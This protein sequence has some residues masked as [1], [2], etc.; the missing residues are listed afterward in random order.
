MTTE[1]LQKKANLPPDHIHNCVEPLV[2]LITPV[3]ELLK[4]F[5]RT[6]YYGSKR[7]LIRWLYS[8]FS[9]YN[10]STVLDLFGGTASVSQLFRVMN[11]K[12]TYHDAFLFNVDVANTILSNTVATT[13]SSVLNFIKSVTTSSGIIANNFEGIFFLRE[14]N[15]WLDGFME[16]LASSCSEKSVKHLMMYLLYQACLKKRPFNLFH[17]ANL[18]LRINSTVSRSFG[19]SS[20]WEKSFPCHIMETYDD[21]ASSRIQATYDATILSPQ[22]VQNIA[23]AFD[24]VYLDPPYINVKNSYNKDDYWRRYHFLEGLATYGNTWEKIIDKNSAIRLSTPSRHFDLWANKRTSRE[25]L[26]ELIRTHRHSIVAL[27]YVANA[28]PSDE[29]IKNYFESLFSEVSIHSL[30]YS[31]ALS[32]QRRRE[33]LYIGKPK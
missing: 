16:K 8:K 11:K 17:R 6:R 27:S 3:P 30:E 33:L 2:H 26:F 12:V 23:P 25:A 4:I 5:P 1:M 14:E 13:R 29:E 19:N 15:E 24:L 20:T 22:D 18:N 10:Y 31:R 32:R 9:P 21:L 7:R 28:Y